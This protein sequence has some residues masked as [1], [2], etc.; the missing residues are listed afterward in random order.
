MLQ[1][2]ITAPSIKASMVHRRSWIAYLDLLGVKN[3]IKSG[4]L[5]N[6]VSIYMSAIEE[7]HDISGPKGAYGIHSMWFSDTFLIYSS[8]DKP[9]SF[10]WLEMTTRHFFEKLILS[11]VPLRGAI[12]IGNLYTNKKKGV[13]VGD[14]LVSAYE[15]GEA[16]DWI[17]LLLTPQVV[18]WMYVNGLNPNMRLNYARLYDPDVLP[19]VPNKEIF[20]Y[21]MSESKPDI[22]EQEVYKKVKELGSLAPKKVSCKYD[23]TLKFMRENKLRDAS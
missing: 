17:G 15:W 2:Y 10:A 23:R 4:L 6:V 8:N 7:L 13:V 9:G 11:G 3:L 21:R 19:C 12:S 1:P 22:E 5:V 16:Q 18:E 14:A 20:A